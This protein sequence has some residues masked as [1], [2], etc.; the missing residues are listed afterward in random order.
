M[1]LQFR[2]G[3]ADRPRGHA[4]AYFETSDGRIYATYIVIPPIQIDLAK[5]MPPMFAGQIPAQAAAE[6]SAMPLPPIPE[7][8]AGGLIALDR[9][10][11]LRED[12]LVAAGPVD[13]R[14]L[15]RLLMVAAEAGQAYVALYKSWQANALTEPPA[16]EEPSYDVDEVLLSLESEHDRIGRLARL[17]GQLRYALD[18]GD[19]RMAEEALAEMERVGRTLP[20]KYRVAELVAAANRPGQDGARLAK[21]LLE[22]SYKL[23]QEEYAEVARIEAEI[24]RLTA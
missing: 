19:R 13:P 7:E 23:C 21:L 8:V 18:G 20:E 12:D 11:E 4:L 17:V 3:A 10:A 22:R 5:Y 6:L 2:R 1:S 16:R 15:D 9:L 24:K 14:A